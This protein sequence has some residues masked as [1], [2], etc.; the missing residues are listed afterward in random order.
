[1]QSAYT[2]LS[3]V[4]DIDRK[5][6]MT[7]EENL[8]GG[9]DMSDGFVVGSKDQCEGACQHDPECEA[10]SFINLPYFS[11]CQYHSTAMYQPRPA[12]SSSSATKVCLP[13]K[14]SFTIFVFIICCM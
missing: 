8:Y 14:I 4:V 3:L 5:C 6:I 13:G 9:N 1:M 7:S 12:Y 11:Y 10:P 2:K